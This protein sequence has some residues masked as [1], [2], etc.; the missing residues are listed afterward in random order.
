MNKHG[1]GLRKELLFILLFLMCLVVSTIGLN[2]MGLLDVNPNSIS[3]VQSS[4]SYSDMEL[5]LVVGAKEYVNK[6]YGG[7]SIKDEINIKYFTLYYNN[8]MEKLVDSTGNE[9]SGYVTV[10]N[11]NSVLIYK[12]YLKCN[13]YKTSGYESS[14][15]W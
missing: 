13:R 7:D 6:Y 15:D 5:K 1:W 2:Q 11:T 12:P 4:G 3:T 9:C 14:K 8:Y 10:T